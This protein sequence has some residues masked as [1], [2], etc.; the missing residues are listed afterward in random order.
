MYLKRD[1][2]IM[3]IIGTF[4]E[5]AQNHVRS[6]IDHLHESSSTFLNGDK[7]RKDGIIFKML[8]NYQGSSLLLLYYLA[9][10]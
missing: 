4:Q 5:T 9:D 3:D 7:V 8:L 1:L 10:L 6:L 2:A